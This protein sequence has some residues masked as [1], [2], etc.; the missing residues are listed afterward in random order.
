M[1]DLQKNQGVAEERPKAKLKEKRWSFPVVW[2]V[3]VV[4]AIVAAYLV[5]DRVRE[6]GPSI[7]IRFQHAGGLRPGHTPINYRGVPI[8][9]VTAV[10]LSDDRQHVLVK[11]RLRRSGASIAREGT[12]F[13][14][15]RPEVGF[16][17]IT[18]L[19]TVITGPQIEALP[20]AGEPKSVFVG[21][22]N[23]PVA[24]ERKG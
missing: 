13:W 8:G 5:Y 11:A 12:V 9:E 20:G 15:V 23:P 10:E 21:L 7:T 24:L 16:G 18:G 4:A 22:E 2:V 3:P 19:G 14:I 6:F 17:N 1:N